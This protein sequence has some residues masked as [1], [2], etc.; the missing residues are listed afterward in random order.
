MSENI[1]AIA[2]LVSSIASLGM[3]MLHCR[4]DRTRFHELERPEAKR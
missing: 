3:L 2:A 1:I 4:R